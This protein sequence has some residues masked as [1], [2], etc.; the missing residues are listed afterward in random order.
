MITLTESAEERMKRLVGFY[1]ELPYD[2]VL[3][4][5][6]LLDD[7]NFNDDEKAV[8]AYELFIGPFDFKH[9]NTCLDQ[10]KR[11]LNYISLNPYTDKENVGTT[12]EDDT[13][14]FS[15][16][17]DAEAIFASFFFVG[18][19]LVEQRGK[20]SWDVFKAV[21]DN[22]PEE[23][24]FVRIVEIRK[25]NTAQL[26]PDQQPHMLQLQQKYALKATKTTYSK[27][28]QAQ[29]MFDVLMAAAD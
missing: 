27:N 24:P 10:L 1:I 25:T 7:E 5:Y 28:K 9:M 15:F 18:I 4:F 14:H 17:E 16:T 8:L 21:L 3:K 26:S 23:S 29:N 11:L 19:N 20:M 22:L 6:E 13:R 2:S 12:E